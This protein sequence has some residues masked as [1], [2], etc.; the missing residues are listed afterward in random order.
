MACDLVR[1]AW[2]ELTMTG[3]GVL[4]LALMEPGA[5]QVIKERCAKRGGS[6]SATVQ[7]ALEALEMAAYREQLPPVAGRLR[8]SLYDGMVHFGIVR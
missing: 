2:K 8:M 5:Q 6:Y 1:G 3:I 4:F 7:A